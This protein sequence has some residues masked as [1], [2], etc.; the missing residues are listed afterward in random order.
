MYE[1]KY[2]ITNFRKT[3]GT[4]KCH[5]R[6]LKIIIKARNHN[7][8]TEIERLTVNR[9]LFYLF[10]FDRWVFDKHGMGELGR[11]L[12]DDYDWRA[13]KRVCVCSAGGSIC[14]SSGKWNVLTALSNFQL[15]T[16]TNVSCTRGTL[17]LVD[18]FPLTHSGHSASSRWTKVFIISILKNSL[19]FLPTRGE[20]NF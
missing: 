11:W 5:R 18:C 10:S 20:V 13:G 8:W 14:S 2:H 16:F 9:L 12:G 19:Y 7:K 4:S 17:Y 6:Q 15:I 3:M 1:H